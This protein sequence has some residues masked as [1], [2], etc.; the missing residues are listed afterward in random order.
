MRF[1]R[2]RAGQ[3][4]ANLEQGLSELENAVTRLS[5]SRSEFY[6]ELAEANRRAGH[7]ER[8]IT[9]YEES[10]ARR[11]AHWRHFYQLGVTLTALGKTERGGRIAARCQWRGGAGCP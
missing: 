11:P 10:C 1:M 4:D 3:D 7:L 5:P 8:A 6:F 2:H 9:F